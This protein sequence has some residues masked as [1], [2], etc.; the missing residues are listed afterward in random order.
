M[1]QASRSCALKRATYQQEAI[2]LYKRM[3]FRPRGPF[4]PYV[5]MPRC[6]IEINLFFEK[7][8]PHLD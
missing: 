2:G 8:L 6:N 3:G 1:Q 5:A 4:G 7:E